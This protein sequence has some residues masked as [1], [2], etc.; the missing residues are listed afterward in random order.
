MKHNYL[1]N[2]AFHSVK[3]KITLEYLATSLTQEEVSQGFWLNETLIEESISHIGEQGRFNLLW[4]LLGHWINDNYNYEQIFQF[5]ASVSRSNFE[6][7]H[8][9][10]VVIDIRIERLL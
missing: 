4:E 10:T 2:L 6:I 1:I 9:E 3:E 7:F 8:D 5:N